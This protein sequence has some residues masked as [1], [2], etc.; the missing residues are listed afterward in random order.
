[1][2]RLGKPISKK[3]YLRRKNKVITDS[4]DE[5]INEV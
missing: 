4:G 1:M 5:D 3:Y 2:Q